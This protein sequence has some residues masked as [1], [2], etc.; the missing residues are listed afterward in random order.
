MSSRRALS[1]VQGMGSSGVKV[2]GKLSVPEHRTNLD[3]SLNK[4]ET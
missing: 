3:N 1:T 4:K 2:L